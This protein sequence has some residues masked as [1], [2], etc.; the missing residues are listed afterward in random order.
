MTH[1]QYY[2]QMLA[3]VAARCTCPRRQ[4]GAIIVDA[5]H[6]VLSTGFNGVPRGFPH[7]IDTG[8]AT[9][10]AC[11]GRQDKHGDTS[12]CLAVHAEANAILQ[13]SRLDLARTIYVSCTPCFECAKLL[14]NT[15]IREIVALEEYT[16]AGLDVLLNAG[17]MVR[18]PEQGR[19]IKAVTYDMN[20]VTGNS[21]NLSI[22][23]RWCDDICKGRLDTNSKCVRCGAQY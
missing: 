10:A 9:D 3:L 1:D 21:Q 15:Q 23:P 6:R 2:L 12:R 17:F 5:D 7:C 22:P 13:C 14:A 20:Y 19:M 16:G 8:G 4:V 18:L 11:L